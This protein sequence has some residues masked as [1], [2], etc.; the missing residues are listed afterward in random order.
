MVSATVVISLVGTSFGLVLVIIPGVILLVEWAVAAQA[1]ALEKGGWMDALRRSR[2]PDRRSLQTRPR[3][4]GADL[5]TR[6]RAL[7]L[8]RHRLR[9]HDDTVASFTADTALETFARSFIAL[10]TAVLYFDLNA[11]FA[12]RGASVEDPWSRVPLDALPPPT[13]P[14]VEPNGNPLDPMSWS[15]EDRPAGWYVDLDAPWKMRYWENDGKGWSKQTAK[16][17]KQTLAEWR[18]PRWKR[19]TGD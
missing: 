5:R 16:T 14:K 8:A 13:V 18:D 15:D 19:E 12:V 6:F 11:R 2:R 4:G 1:A 7:L 9:P 3:T 10:A 17:P